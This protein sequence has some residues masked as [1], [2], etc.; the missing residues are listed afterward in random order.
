MPDVIEKYSL[1]P[2]ILSK[3]EPEEEEKQESKI[4]EVPYG[5]SSGLLD[6]DQSYKAK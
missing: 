2:K 5:P 4:K 6:L 1:T 3:Q